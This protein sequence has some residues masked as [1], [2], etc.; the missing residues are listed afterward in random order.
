MKGILNLARYGGY[1]VL[2]WFLAY[3]L[4]FLLRGDSLDFGYFL[5]YLFLGWTFT[6]FELPMFMWM[7]SIVIFLVFVFGVDPI[8]K[9]KLA[10]WAKR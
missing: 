2:S 7:F 3:V 1:Y 8:L 6:G 5:E 10:Q 4:T 9:E